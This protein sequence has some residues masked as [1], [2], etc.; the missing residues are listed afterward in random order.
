MSNATEI[1]KNYV[2]VSVYLCLMLLRHSKTINIPKYTLLLDYIW[3][4][5]AS[6]CMV[7]V[8]NTDLQSRNE[9]ATYGP[10]IGVQNPIMSH[11]SWIS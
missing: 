7:S 4:I 5:S 2:K 1:F 10:W 8:D 11:S 3:S 6:L 9:L